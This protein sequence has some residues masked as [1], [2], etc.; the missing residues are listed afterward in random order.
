MKPF[1]SLNFSTSL[2]HFIV[3]CMERIAVKSFAMTGTQTWLPFDA[4]WLEAAR[5]SE[6]LLAGCEDAGVAEVAG[7]AGWSVVALVESEVSLPQLQ[8]KMT[9]RTMAK[10]AGKM[11]ATL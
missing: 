7:G 5:V 3:N 6:T 11:L 4:A 8:V 1:T 9:S 2:S 10:R